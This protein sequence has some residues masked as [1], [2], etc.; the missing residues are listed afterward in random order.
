MHKIVLI[1]IAIVEVIDFYVIK[2]PLC[3]GV[4]ATIARR[5]TKPRG[6]EIVEIR[7]GNVIRVGLVAPSWLRCLIV[8][9]TKIVSRVDRPHVLRGTISTVIKY[10]FDGF[11]LVTSEYL[12]LFV[13]LIEFFRLRIDLGSIDSLDGEGQVCG[14][15]R[16]KPV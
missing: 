8:Q 7:T 9:I 16:K 14:E 11:Q 6:S 4:A 5:E 12:T 15:T 2:E 10:Y 13:V 1:K 3:I